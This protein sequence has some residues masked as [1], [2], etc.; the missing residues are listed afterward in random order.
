MQNSRAAV[1][2]EAKSQQPLASISWDRIPGV[3]RG[4]EPKPE[5]LRMEMPGL[6]IN[7]RAPLCH[8]G[9]GK[10]PNCLGLG[11]SDIELCVIS[12]FRE[13]ISIKALVAFM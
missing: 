5:G 8:P 11:L 7:S 3:Q 9:S 10:K 4:A 1:Q 13:W 6:R 12:G 2:G